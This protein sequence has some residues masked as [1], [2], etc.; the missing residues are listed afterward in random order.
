MFEAANQEMSTAYTQRTVKIWLSF[1]LG[2][3]NALIALM[4]IAISIYWGHTT[5]PG[6]I[7]LGFA[8]VMNFT[9]RFD[10]LLAMVQEMQTCMASI[11]RLHSFINNTPQER[12]EPNPVTVPEDWPQR[13]IVEFENVTAKYQ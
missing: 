13:G 3:L 9:S 11:V 2:G 5:S 7:G 1:L 10:F 6:L 12:D 8:G 4:L